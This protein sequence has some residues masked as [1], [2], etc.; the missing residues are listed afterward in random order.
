[1]SLPPSGGELASPRATVL[2]SL[3]RYGT[4][5]FGHPVLHDE[6]SIV[7]GVVART[8]N[9]VEQFFS[10]DKQGLRRRTGRAHLARDLQQQPAQAAFVYNLKD[11]AYV[12]ILCGSL[13]RLPE[14][15]ASLGIGEAHQ[16][17][18]VRD[19][20]DS[21]LLRLIRSFEDHPGQRQSTATST[22]PASV[23]TTVV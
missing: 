19:H 11:P 9:V 3:D 6:A 1:M 23:S 5:L 22:P 18:L 13:E 7:V 15:L 17:T 16:G 8:N 14:A 21:R 12:A 10:R 2:K 4:G 20:R